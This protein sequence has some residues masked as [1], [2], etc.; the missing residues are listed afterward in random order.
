MAVPVAL[1]KYAKRDEPGSK[2]SVG[3]RRGNFAEPDDHV[4]IVADAFDTVIGD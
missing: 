2:Q 4:L 1:A 3:G